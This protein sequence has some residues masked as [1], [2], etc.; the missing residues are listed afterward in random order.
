MH[1]R[2]PLDPTSQRGPEIHI[3]AVKCMTFTR[4]VF[5]RIVIPYTL[6]VQNLD[7]DI[8]TLIE[9]DPDAYIAIVP[10]GAGNKYFR[11]NPRANA[12]ILAF[13]KSLE[14]HEEG[15]SLSVAKALP[16]N[17][18]NQKREF[19]KPWT[20]ILSGAGKNLRDYLVWHQTFAVHPE[21]TFS[22][23]PFDK[24]LQSWVIMNISGDLVEKS[25]EAQVNAL[26]AIK[27]K[28]WR[29]PAFRSYAD[30]LLAAQNVAGS[31][32]ERACRATKT[33]D[34]TYIETQDSEGNPAPIWQLTGKPLTKDPI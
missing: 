19:E 13:I 33:F 24:D 11:D 17:K 9:A 32:S 15:D 1:G 21:L 12:N 5:P 28:L 27:H 3:P 22:A 4:A 23:L 20:M 25:R 18:P 29:N 16:R 10:F 7:A 14:L 30:R 6:L 31:T 34:V 26:G 2:K 8:E